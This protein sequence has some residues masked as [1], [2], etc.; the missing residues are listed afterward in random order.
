MSVPVIVGSGLAGLTVARALSPQPCIL[1]T[2]A[3]LTAGAAS[4]WAQGGIAA[5]LGADDSPALHAAD[6]RRAGAN[7]GDDHAIARITGAAPDVVRR[8]QQQGVPFDLDPSGALDLALEGG[9]SRHRIAHAGDRS[10]AAITSA[11]A[12][13]VA[14]L[15]SVDIR[16]GHRAR[17]LVLDDAGRVAGL[18]AVSP[19]G[20]LIE[21]PTNR[22]VLATG[23]LGGLFAHTT[24]PRTALGGGIAI[25]SRAGARTDDLHFVQFHPTALD[26][27]LDPM[28]LLTEALRGAGAV[29]LSDGERFVEELL[30]RDVVAAAVWSQAQAGRRVMLDARTVPDVAD[31]FPA[32][33]ELVGAAGLDL[34]RDRLPVAPAVH[35][36]MGGV[37]VDQHSRTSVPG[38]WAVGEVA[39]T[40]LHGANRLASNSLLEAVVS[41]EAAAVD[42]AGSTWS[43]GSVGLA[44]PDPTAQRRSSHRSSSRRPGSDMTLHEVRT[45]LHHAC[46]VLR[47]AP[48][49]QAAV[50][51][52]AGS[53][54][55]DAAYVGW[56]IAR[57]ALADP[58]SVGAHRRVE[59]APPG[60]STASS[61]A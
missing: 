60:I 12:H 43:A 23:G 38:L 39:R 53:T 45:T 57:S 30:P 52:L 44:Q 13:H 26:V 9:H 5:A 51:R 22:V 37:T 49:M 28:P 4:R 3:E 41:A 17:E 14:D 33:A 6:T 36:S 46:G 20:D 16:E 8:M 48:E 58:R 42:L 35:Y 25:A 32:V 54:Q 29:L 59:T 18:I 50:D 56:L 34:T 31:R 2:A 7:I 10:G 47:A 21:V 61:A 40:G 11:V 19:T 27:G 24:N 15:D 1:L 55:D